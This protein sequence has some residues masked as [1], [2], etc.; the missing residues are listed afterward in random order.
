MSIPT[1]SRIVPNIPVVR[2]ISGS[3]PGERLITL[4]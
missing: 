2:W 3:I 1:F 4:A